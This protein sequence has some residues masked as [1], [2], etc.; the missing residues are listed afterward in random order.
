MRI[1]H[2]VT[3]VSPDGAFGG[4]ARVALGHAEALAERGHDV[5]VYAAAPVAAPQESAQD[6]YLLRTF[7]AHS[8]SKR[9]GFAGMRARGLN[10]ALQAALPNLDVAHV[11]LARDLVT[12][13]AVRTIRRAGVPYVV[14]PHGMIDR[15]TNPLAWP[16][17]RWE[18]RKALRTA[19]AVLSLTDQE[20]ADIDEVAP[21]VRTTRIVNGIKIA[22]AATYGDREPLVLFLARLQERKRPVAF[23]EMAG[24]LSAKL[25]EHRFVLAGPDEGEG[26]AVRR[27]IAQSPL[28]DRLEWVGAIDADD[29]DRLMRQASVYVLPAV[30]EVFPM[31]V[32]EALR[33]G[34]PTVV[35]ESLGIADACRAHG[36][37]VITDGSPVQLAAAVG[38]VVGNSAVA[39]RLR[40]GGVSYLRSELDIS[41]V[42][43]DLER[44]Y[45]SA[46]SGGF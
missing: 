32:L 18:T 34:T 8:I 33:A 4:P 15:S 29:T 11:H 45:R 30:D 16:I 12:L 23:V 20:D 27:A 35:T 1:A 17:D 2:V 44:H 37:A 19:R 42:A 25:P 39:E 36:A 46:A 26:D 43:A 6:G 40:Q 21:G 10:A 22:D 28:P 24:I 9:L 7:P 13:P 38:S 41:R 3:Y 14:Q 5:T 31:T